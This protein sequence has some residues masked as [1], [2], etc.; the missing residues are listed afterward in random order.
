MNMETLG[1]NTMARSTAR[2]SDF[3]PHMPELLVD[4]ATCWRTI[5]DAQTE[6]DP[7]GRR[8]D[9]LGGGQGSAGDAGFPLHRATGLPAAGGPAR[10]SKGPPRQGSRLKAVLSRAGPDSAFG[11]ALGGRQ[12]GLPHAFTL[13]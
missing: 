13:G 7:F 8:L 6:V 4:V 2:D 5:R 1:G 12:R 3:I 11:L 9:A 10:V